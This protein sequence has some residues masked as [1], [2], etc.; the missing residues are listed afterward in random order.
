M[1]LFKQDL[2]ANIST[3]NLYNVYNIEIISSGFVPATIEIKKGD[4]IIWENKDYALH[5]V[6]SLS[7]YKLDSGKLF[8]GQNYSE[9]F[10]NETTI[11]YHCLYHPYARGK[12]IVTNGGDLF[13]NK[14]F[15]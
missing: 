4:A 11:E 8:R 14:G 15:F 1:I 13:T 5:R 12:I 10:N 6:V 7:G 9:I 3:A 2:K